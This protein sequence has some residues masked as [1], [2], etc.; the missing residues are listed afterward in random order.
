MAE[1][2]EV[3]LL[4]KALSE[5]FEKLSGDLD[6]LGKSTEKPAEPAKK[7][8]LSFTELKSAL[9]L[10]AGAAQTAG[11]VFK[12]AFDFAQLGASVNQ[13]AESFDTMLGV[14]GVA[15]DLLTRLEAAAG[16][17][18]PTMKLASATST[19]LA[20]AQG[21]LGVALANA[22]PRLLEIARAANKLNPSLG[23]TTF[24]YESL[25]T[26]IKRA[27]PMILDNLGLT[28]KIG[29]ANEAMAVQ[30]GKSVEALTN[31]EKQMALLNAALNAGD[32]LINQVG[33]SVESAVDPFNKLTA[34]TTNLKNALAGMVASSGA[35]QYVTDGLS[36]NFDATTK[37]I[38]MHRDGIISTSEAWRLY[39]GISIP[40]E[41]EETIRDLVTIMK[42]AENE[43][44]NLIIGT[45]EMTYAQLA[46]ADA[47]DN[48]SLVTKE[49]AE[50]TFY[51]EQA[52]SMQADSTYE[53][54]VTSEKFAD[55]LQLVN[56]K[57][58]QLGEAMREAGPPVEELM[59]TLKQDISSP[60]GAF[61]D[62]LQFFIASG[63]QD[64]AGAFEAIK[65][66]LAGQQITAGEAQEFSGELLAS[67]ENVKIAAGEIT[68]DEAAANLSETL[69]VPLEDAVR[70]LGEVGTAAD[71]VFG[72][73]REISLDTSG[74]ESAYNILLGME[75]AV[76][77]IEGS[78][79]VTINVTTNG[80][81]PSFTGPGGGQG[82]GQG[83]TSSVGLAEGAD[84][85]V[86]PGFPNDS[87]GP[88]Y[89]QS[90]ER[91]QVTPAGQVESGGGSNGNTIVQVFLDGAQ[92][93]ARVNTYTGQNARRAKNSGVNRP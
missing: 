27:S 6:K 43:T 29:E 47:T 13:T 12:G 82:Q 68:F 64:F 53:A 74:V 8:S 67:I 56:D 7:T 63:G 78:H 23:D 33:G 73:N 83:G 15:P 50:N 75:D 36:D 76:R 14:M 11:A 92:I 88:L 21:D 31:E 93:A 34:S 72:L 58:I 2:I 3:D 45:T 28:I 55:R 46:A 59:D 16:G 66:A 79:D 44:K 86:P 54:Y 84:F 9:D 87:F 26:G 89:V 17:T 91:V 70:L 51:A 42:T 20:G 61:I 77:M 48:V 30:L 24:L 5:G 71:V 32:V 39:S 4:I 49:W 19:L 69:N 18:V 60:L 90:G 81:V 40:R 10:V 25:A 38:E 57:A 41:K 22:T 1:Q 37:I 52:I 65:N 85:I 62:D 80:T 35:V